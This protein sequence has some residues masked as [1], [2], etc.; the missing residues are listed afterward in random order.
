M[1]FLNQY[2]TFNFSQFIASNTLSQSENCLAGNILYVYT[3]WVCPWLR[4]WWTCKFNNF[5]FSSRQ[6]LF[7]FQIG[8][9]ITIS[10]YLFMSINSLLSLQVGSHFNW[11]FAFFGEAI[12]MIPF[13]VMGFV[14]KPLQ[15]KGTNCPSWTSCDMIQYSLNN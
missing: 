7:Q 15:L 9:K 4:V 6:L 1:I 12:L 13:A 10:I 14:M 8:E 2:L 11:R 5:L 3:N